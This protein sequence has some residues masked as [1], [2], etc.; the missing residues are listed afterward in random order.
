MEQPSSF[1]LQEAVGIRRHDL[2]MFIPFLPYACRS[3]T[4]R[5]FNDLF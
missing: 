1:V 4:L 5:Y 2:C 3:I